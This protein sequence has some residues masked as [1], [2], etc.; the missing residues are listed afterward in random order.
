MSAGR[1]IDV[2]IR[3]TPGVRRTEGVLDGIVRV[4][5]KGKRAA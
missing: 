2:G 5:P 3:M 1:E 4:K